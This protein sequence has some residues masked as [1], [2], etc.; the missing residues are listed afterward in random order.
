M[1]KNRFFF[2]LNMAPVCVH[3]CLCAS[4]L[5]DIGLFQ[6]TLQSSTSPF[7][8]PARASHLLQVIGPPFRGMSHT[9]LRLY[10][11]FIISPFLRFSLT[12]TFV[13]TKFSSQNLILH[14][15]L[16]KTGLMLIKAVSSG[17]KYYSLYF[18][19]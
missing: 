2:L 19:R 9:I 13:Y 18:L 15:D 14:I 4:P 8:H 1:S 16:N 12:F 5:L 11:I 17:V 10:H 7:F 6:G 3:T